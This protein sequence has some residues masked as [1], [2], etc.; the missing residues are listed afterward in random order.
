MHQADEVWAGVARHLFGDREGRRWGPPRIG[1]YWDY[2]RI[3]G[4][5]R[6]HS[7]EHKW[8]TFRLF[9]SLDG[10]LAAHRHPELAAEVTSAAGAARLAPGSRVLVQPRQLQ[11]PRR[12]ASWWDYS[13]PL[14]VVFNGG[15]GSRAGEL[16][17]PVRL[18]QGAGRWPR[19]LDALG[20]P[21]RWHK[22]DLVRRRDASAAGG[23]AYEA[24]LMVLGP[25]YTS[26]A[27][28]A[29]REAAAG[30]E[31]V[32]GVDGNVS[33]L[34]VVSF[35]S[36]CLPEDGEVAST[37]V[38]LSSVELARLARERRRTRARQRALDRSRRAGSRCQYELSRRQRRR[39]ERR[40][41]AGLVERQVAVPGGA[42]MTDERG[43][44]RQRYRDDRLSAG[45]RHTRAVQAEAAASLA[46]AQAQ[47]AARLPS[48][49]S[50][51]RA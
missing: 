21:E 37:R 32:G 10:H 43:R 40:A 51:V 25:G 35:P 6:S 49:P 12:P 44:P 36:S 33:N 26:P 34:A 4:R 42:R 23:W 24:H 20:R 18:P 8:E 13:G 29:R 47:R 19:L 16:V 14:V 46:G 9:G 7:S 48:W 41:A 15:P 22:V 3:A 27:T 38:T 39:A 1:R 50:T 2:R 28:R 5:A 17:L 30:L 31:R 45:Y 11:P